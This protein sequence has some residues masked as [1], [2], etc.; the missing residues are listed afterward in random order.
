[1]AYSN[2]ANSVPPLLAVV[3]LVLAVVLWL[4]W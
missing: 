3:L 1:M 4:W 2:R